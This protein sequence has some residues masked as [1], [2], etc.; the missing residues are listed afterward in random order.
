MNVLTPQRL[1]VQPRET[2]KLRDSW[3]ERPNK[4]T[5]QSFALEWNTCPRTRPLPFRLMHVEFP[6]ERLEVKAAQ[7]ESAARNSRN[8]RRAPKLE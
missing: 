4:T 6:L 1:G 2:G 5:I 8:F 7:I 3:L